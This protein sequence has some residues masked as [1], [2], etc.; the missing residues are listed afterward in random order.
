[1]DKIERARQLFRILEGD[2]INANEIAKRQF[3]I[4]SRLAELRD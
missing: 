2:E 4:E 3:I 1:M